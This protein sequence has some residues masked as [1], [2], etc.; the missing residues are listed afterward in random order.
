MVIALLAGSAIFG[1]VVKR[2]AHRNS[3]VYEPEFLL[4][5]C[6]PGVFFFVLGIVGWGWG[7]EAGISWVGLAFFFAFVN[8]GAVMYN[9]AVIGYV[10]DAHREYANESQV[11]IF[12]IK[13]LYLS[14][15]NPLTV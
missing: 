7:E 11:I 4:Y 3:N 10:I 5:Q 1:I 9:N 2:L 8:G 14:R 15:N 12:A 13:V 6:I